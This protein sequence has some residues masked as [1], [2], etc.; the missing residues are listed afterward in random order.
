MNTFVKSFFKLLN[1][2]V[3]N[4]KHPPIYYDSNQDSIVFHNLYINRDIPHKLTLLKEHA[5]FLTDESISHLENIYKGLHG[6]TLIKQELKK[7]SLNNS[8]CLHNVLLDK[9]SNTQQGSQLDFLLITTRCIFIIESKWSSSKEIKFD[10]DNYFTDN[11]T[12]NPKSQ[13]ANQWMSLYNTIDAPQYPSLRN[14]PIISI[15]VYANND[16]LLIN[17]NTNNNHEC[18]CKLDSLNATIIE[19]YRNQKNEYSYSDLTQL[20]EALKASTN[21]HI[22]DYHLRYNA[23]HKEDYIQFKNRFICPNHNVVMQPRWKKDHFFLV[24]PYSDG[25]SCPTQS[26]KDKRY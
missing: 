13:L 2:T 6:E 14:I 5:D 23:L 3:K 4:E 20:A 18:I 26:I 19:H 12:H 17:K 11:D 8:I 21:N 15:L 22:N 10:K 24:C 1:K 7:L 9:Y 16:S 25:H